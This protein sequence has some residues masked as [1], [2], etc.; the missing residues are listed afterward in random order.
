[1]TSADLERRVRQ[2]DNDIA[3]IYGMMSDVQK[4]QEVHTRRFDELTE[5]V[6]GLRTDLTGLSTEFTGL[7]SE[8]TGLRTDLTG[9]QGTVNQILDLVRGDR[10]G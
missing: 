9:L 10:D 4:T 5:V 8:V 3:A 1:M 7:R 6:T 2:H